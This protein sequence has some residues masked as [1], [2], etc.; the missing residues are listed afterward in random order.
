MPTF[1][2]LGARSLGGAIA[3]ALLA[4]GWSGAAIARSE[5]TLEAIRNRGMTALQADAMDP[6]QVAD[7]LRLAGEA[8]GHVD[9]LI[10]AV[11]V[12]KFDP[13]VP[14]GGGPLVDAD[15]D[16]WEAWG[17]AVGK[18]ALVFFS[19]AAR[20]AAAQG[21]ALKILQVGNS[22]TRE[23]MPGMGPWAA[24]WH[25]VRAL[26]NAA[27]QEFARS[28]VQVGLVAVM[29]PIRSPKTEAA[30]AKLPP[31]MVNEQGDV[32]AKIAAYVAGDTLES[33]FLVTP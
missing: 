20:F 4:D 13:E 14:W 17:A 22:A 12:A 27:R 25:G 21:G 24:G 31:E 16:R 9:L 23:A 8:L 32:A 2:T 7:A 5:D 26:T 19:E 28:G 3:D 33:D 6:A 29:G 15:L 18:Q 11:S 30:V 1:V 10:N